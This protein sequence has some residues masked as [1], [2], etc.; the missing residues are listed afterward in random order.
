MNGSQQHVWNEPE[1]KIKGD[2]SV[3]LFSKLSLSAYM[4]L[5]GGI[6]VRDISGNTKTL[7]PGVDAGFSAEYQLIKRLSVFAQ[8]NN[9]FN[10]KYQRWYGYEAY[11]L[12]IYG[13]IRFKF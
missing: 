12:N 7:T 1:M 3:L 8:V 13:G 11:G 5:L 9:L 2:F 6:Y 4:E 10:D